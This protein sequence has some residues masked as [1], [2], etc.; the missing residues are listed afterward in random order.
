MKVYLLQDVKTV[1]YLDGDTIVTGNLEI[2]HKIIENENLS[3]EEVNATRG[4]NNVNKFENE[5]A[6]PEVI[7]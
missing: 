6:L 1:V 7:W 3:A 2:I 5:V 4:K